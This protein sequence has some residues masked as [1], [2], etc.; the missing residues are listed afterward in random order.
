M[1]GNIVKHANQLGWK[2]GVTGYEVGLFLHGSRNLKV[3]VVKGDFISNQNT[4]I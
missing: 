4:E 2:I 3:K 1:Q